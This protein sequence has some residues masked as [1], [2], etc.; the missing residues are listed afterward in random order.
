MPTG[1]THHNV[2]LCPLTAKPNVRLHRS[3]LPSRQSP[4]VCDL[5]T[6]STPRTHPPCMHAHMLL[7]A[8]Y[9]TLTLV[10][11]SAK[12]AALVHGPK[13]LTKSYI[14]FVSLHS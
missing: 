12:S 14:N 7:Q 6:P 11:H 4:H 8:Q 9:S 10:P 5:L 13:K 3:R 1:G 2:S